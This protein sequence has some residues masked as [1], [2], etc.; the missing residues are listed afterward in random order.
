MSHVVAYL[1]GLVTVPALIV[2]VGAVADVRDARRGFGKHWYWT[3]EGCGSYVKTAA[4]PIWVPGRLVHP[5]LV[6]RS[7]REHVAAWSS[8]RHEDSGDAGMADRFHAKHVAA[9]MVLR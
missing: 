4:I 1:V 7:R 3:C 5:L 9:G 6:R 8:M 2:V